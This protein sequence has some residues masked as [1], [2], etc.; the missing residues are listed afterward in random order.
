MIA[1]EATEPVRH[2]WVAQRAAGPTTWELYAWGRR[3]QSNGGTVREFRF[4]RFGTAGGRERDMAEV[5]LAA[6]AT[7][8]GHPAPWPGIWSKPFQVVKVDPAAARYVRVLE[9]GLLDGSCK[10]LFEGTPEQAEN[11]YK[12]HARDR[13]RAV[14]SG[15]AKE[16]GSACAD[17]KLVTACDTLPRHPGLLGISD[18]AAPPRTWSVS[19]DATTSAARPRTI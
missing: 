6:Y 13:V 16:P 18:P 7:A 17:C 14:S 12:E 3:Y 2:Y 5:A 10:I 15:R 11:I 8:Y 4:L 9:V 19:T 1:T